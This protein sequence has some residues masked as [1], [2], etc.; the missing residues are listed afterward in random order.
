MTTWNTPQAVSA[1]PSTPLAGDEYQ[2]LSVALQLNDNTKSWGSLAL[3]ATGGRYRFLNG[4]TIK[5]FRA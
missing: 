2:M 3:S 5:L 4:M 1:A